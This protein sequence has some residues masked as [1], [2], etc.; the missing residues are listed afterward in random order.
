VTGT[1]LTE[2][3]RAGLKEPGWYGIVQTANGPKRFPIAKFKNADTAWD[4]REGGIALLEAEFDPEF[5]A[6]MEGD[7]GL[8]VPLS[9]HH[10]L[11]LPEPERNEV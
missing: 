6:E 3:I 8:A 7:L 2:Y 10:P 11:Y 9:V 1:T 4:E 5:R